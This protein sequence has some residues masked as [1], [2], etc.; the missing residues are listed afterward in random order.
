MVGNEIG[1][2]AKNIMGIAAGMLDG[3]EYPSLKGPL[4][5]RGA[6]EIS[7]YTSGSTDFSKSKNR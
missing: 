3:L 5:A 1:A 4:M 6:R 7:S 2:A